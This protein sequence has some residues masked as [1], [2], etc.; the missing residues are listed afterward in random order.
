MA[1]NFVINQSLKSVNG[2]KH[3]VVFSNMSERIATRSY[4]DMV[5][6]N[7]GEYF[8]LIKVDHSEVCLQFTKLDD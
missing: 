1:I 2:R 8:E 4:N 6:E 5:R 7:P 3:E